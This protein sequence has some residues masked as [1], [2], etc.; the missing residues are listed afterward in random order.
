MGFIKARFIK[1]GVVGMLGMVI[2]FSVTWILKE[3]I[4]VNKYLAN[5][6][7][8]TCAVIFNY[9]L[10]RIWT[11]ESADTHI[12][13]QFSKFLLVALIGLG[14]NN[15]LLYFFVKKTKHNFYL[16]KL[17]VIG[18]V[19]FWNYFANLLITFHS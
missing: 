19:F 18:I 12:A 15:L 4:K 14:I 11:F 10:N 13:E 2:D 7:G 16:L 8:F 1:F 3:K 5:S 17:I 9:T 6:A